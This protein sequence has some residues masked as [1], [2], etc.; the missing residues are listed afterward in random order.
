MPA[1]RPAVLPLLVHLEIVHTLRRQC[2]A[3]VHNAADT[4]TVSKYTA[5]LNKDNTADSRDTDKMSARTALAWR[6][7]ERMEFAAHTMDRIRAP[8]RAKKIGLEVCSHPT[9]LRTDY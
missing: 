2:F 7:T 3:A 5:A 4:N 8:E 6:N 1:G 9:E